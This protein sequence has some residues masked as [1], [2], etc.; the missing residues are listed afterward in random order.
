MPQKPI[1][2]NPAKY[3]RIIVGILRDA[4]VTTLAA[5]V[6]AMVVNLFHPERIPCFAEKEYEILVPCPE[7]GGEV[8]RVEATSPLLRSPETFIVD[9]RPKEAFAKWRFREARNLTYD[10]LDPTPKALI[11]DLAKAIASSRAKQVLVY[12][13]GDEPDTGEQLGKEISGHGIKNVHF[14]KG[15]VKALSSFGA[16]GGER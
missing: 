1:E 14:L 4:S 10:Y 11:E 7:P 12:G 13:D 3:R 8:I 15:G 5:A 6:I 16:P 2:E 9:A